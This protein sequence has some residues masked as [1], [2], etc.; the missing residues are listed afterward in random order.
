MYN[1]IIVDD[2]NYAVEHLIRAYDWNRYDMKVAA[3]FVDGR[4]ALLYIQTHHVDVVLSDIK[5]TFM[6]GIE[7]AKNIHENFPEIIVV[8][9]SGYKEFEYARLAMQYNVH[10]YL[11]KPTGKDD[12]EQAFSEIKETLDSRPHTVLPV[13][14]DLV[15][16]ISRQ[17]FTDVLIGAFADE[18]QLI[19]HLKLT[20]LRL[21]AKHD[22]CCIAEIKFHNF[23]EFIKHE[24]KCGKERF[25][26]SISNFLQT[27]D[28][29]TSYYIF[30]YNSDIIQFIAIGNGISRS[31]LL[32]YVH[33]FSDSLHNNLNEI[34]KLE[35]EVNV[36]KATENIFG[37]SDFYIRSDSS[38]ILPGDKQISSILSYLHSDNANEAINVLNVIYDAL[39]KDIFSARQFT[40]KLISH[41]SELLQP[42]ADA[43]S[44]PDISED[45][46]DADAFRR[47]AVSASKKTALY[48]SVC[49]S[50]NNNLLI[51]KIM[52]YIKE[53]CSED[54]SLDD[55]AEKFSLS[56]VYLSKYFKQH[57]NEKFIDYLSRMRMEK[58][59][60][61]LEN[62]NY[63]VYEIC[64]MVGYNSIRHFYKLFKLFTGF[65]PTEYRNNIL[66]GDGI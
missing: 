24:W 8:L 41:I 2:E 66:K 15:N 40:E 59:M 60:L 46:T 31:E 48:F 49:A 33:T 34:Y 3:T 52:Q 6:S 4:E 58:A 64:E 26:S 42:F 50:A 53:H 22:P 44:V 37:L 13:N 32:G 1:L 30:S 29:K 61:L 21:D 36:L 47:I 19:Q 25:Y 62:P 35:I 54:I 45:I 18:E 23:D 14:D 56:P 65:T 38:A 28:P 27:D 5:M 39:G 55:V 9:L 17:F 7:L 51:N 10:H 12:I 11:L 43:P 57:A 63:K 16:I 20:D